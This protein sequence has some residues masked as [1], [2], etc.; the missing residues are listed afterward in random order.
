MRLVYSRYILEKQRDI[1]KINKEII[2]D[3]IID[4]LLLIA[5]ISDVEKRGNRENR[6]I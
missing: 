1:T 4:E 5:V 2:L 6:I 3:V